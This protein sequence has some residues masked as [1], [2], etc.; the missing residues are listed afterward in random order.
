MERFTQRAENGNVF[1]PH[2]F[3]EC[4]G[5]AETEKCINCEY[6]D[7]LLKR[8][9]DYE[10]TNLTPEQI[11]EIDRLYREKCEELAKYKQLEEQ[12]MLLK[13]PCKVGDTFYWIKK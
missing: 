10:D 11:V 9:F 6:Y 13:L 2:C 4:Q 12:G 1:Y 5:M 7:R 8:F 3:E